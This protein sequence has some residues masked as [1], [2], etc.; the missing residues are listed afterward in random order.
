MRVSVTARHFDLDD[1]LK[2]YIE[3]KV[4]HLTRYFDRIDE[5]HVVLE[6]EGHRKIADV[7]VHASRVIVS[8]EQ[9]A[10]DMRSA[11]DLAM[12]KVERQ[13]RRHKDRIRNRKGAIPTAEAVMELDGAAPRN[14]GVVSEQIGASPMTPEEAL[15]SLDDLGVGFLVF[16]NSD[17]GTVNVIYRRDDGD[18]GLV[19]PKGKVE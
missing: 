19:E 2:G 1:T 12:E 5:A 8:S 14:V 4:E 13:I 18:Y 3:E 16:L 11:V 15:A 17:S 10:D 7:T 9:E 6:S